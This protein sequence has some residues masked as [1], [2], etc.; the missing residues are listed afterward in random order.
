MKETELIIIGASYAFE[1]IDLIKDINKS[2]KKKI[3]II[4][5]LDDDRK[6][7]KKKVFGIPVLGQ[8]KKITSFKNAKINI[9]IN[10]HQRRFVQKKIMKKYNIKQ[11]RLLTLIHPNSFIGSKVN[12]GPGSVIFQ[13]VNIF[14]KVK[15]GISVKIY[16]FAS[17]NPFVKIGNFCTIA[18]GG[19]LAVGSKIGE[20]TFMGIY[21]HISENIEVAKGTMICEKSYVNRD[22]LKKNIKLIGSPAREIL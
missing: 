20:E 2:S 15:I 6:F 8:I 14:S 1:I 12:I 10:N 3:K 11:N 18:V 9:A 21:S 4:G 19:T 7:L 22:F 17:V 5:I 13:F 16:P